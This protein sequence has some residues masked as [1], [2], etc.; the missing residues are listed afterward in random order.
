MFLPRMVKLRKINSRHQFI[1]NMVYGIVQ[2]VQKF[3]KIFLVKENL[4][5][6]IGKALIILIVPLLTFRNGEVVVI[7]PGRFYIKKVGPFAS[8]H[9]LR[10]NFIP[11]I[12]LVLFH[13]FF[14]LGFGV[15]LVES[16]IVV[17]KFIANSTHYISPVITEFG[18]PY[19]VKGIFMPSQAMPVAISRLNVT[20]DSFEPNNCY[21]S[22]SARGQAK[23]R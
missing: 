22:F 15:V 19:K 7:G 10:E 13:R 17:Y 3:V 21:T 8:L 2:R 12:R 4:V 20:F 16:K 14:D 11:A 5:F 23:C 9:F 1:L 6:F 18:S